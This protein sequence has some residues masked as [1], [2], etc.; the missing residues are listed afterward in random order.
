MK[1]FLTAFC[2]LLLLFSGAIPGIFP[3]TVEA[4]TNDSSVFQA[5]LLT[6][7]PSFP[8]GK[9][10]QVGVFM[11]QPFAFQNQGEFGGFA[12]DLWKQIAA[13]LN[14]QFNYIPFTKISDLLKATSDKKIDVAVG[15]ISITGERLN[16]VDFTQPYLQGGMQ[17]MVDEKREASWSRLWNGL[18][19]SGHLRI[20]GI[21][22]V[23]IFVCTL[24]LTLGERKWNTEFPKDW[25]SGLSESFY[26]V[27][28]ISMTGKS[29]HKPLPGPFGKILA[30]IWLAF[31]VAVV[32]YITSSVTS[33]MTV[34]RLQGIINGPQD[35]PGHHVGTVGGT[36]AHQ[37][38]KDQN[39]ETTLYASLPEAVK[40]LV[41]HDIDAIIGD[42]MTL[43]W[44]DNA[45]PELPI[46]EVGPIFMKKGYGL[47]LPIGSPLRHDINRSLLK[48]EESGFLETLRKHYFGDIP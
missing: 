1:R 42:A 2:T 37:Y 47:A 39:L 7:V 20:F 36:I 25:A 33:V 41:R 32:A 21:G 30:G 34:N 38:C 22:I 4:Q 15:N 23:L 45:H 6:N 10:L 3:T 14:L 16:S 27:M 19:D 31:G 43:Q 12:I 35:L 48:Q 44:Y 24:L 26:H 5:E 40:A 28:S 46:T 13:D 18:R 29:S 8:Q 9:K 11:V 17:I